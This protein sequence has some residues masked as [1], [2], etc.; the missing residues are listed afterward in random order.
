L[1]RH[2]SIGFGGLAW[3]WFFGVAI[4]FSCALSDV[5]P[6]FLENLIGQICKID[7]KN[8]IFIE[9]ARSITVKLCQLKKLN[10]LFLA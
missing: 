10:L 6:K 7:L 2:F 1:F 4:V 3:S 9:L 8:I 5:F